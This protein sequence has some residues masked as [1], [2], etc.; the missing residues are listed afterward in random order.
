[1]RRTGEKVELVIVYERV[2]G[3]HIQASVPAVPG[4][5]SVG[6]SR[7]E[8]RTNVID[9]LRMVLTTLQE[10]GRGWR[11]TDTLELSIGRARRRDPNRG[12]DR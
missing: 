10:P 3:G 4:T 1:M 12:L 8:A 11:D 7:D 6:R 5:I 2:E 9:A